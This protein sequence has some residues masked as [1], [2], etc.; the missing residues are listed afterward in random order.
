MGVSVNDDGEDEVLSTLANTLEVLRDGEKPLELGEILHPN[1]LYGWPELELLL[2]EH[3]I[4]LDLWKVLVQR[5]QTHLVL[6][7]QGLVQ[8]PVP[9][10]PPALQI[11]EAGLF[12]LGD[13]LPYLLQHVLPLYL[14]PQ[15]VRVHQEEHLGSYLL[16][17][18][19]Q[20][21]VLPGQPVRVSLQLLYV[22]LDGLRVSPGHVGLLLHQLSKTHSSF[23]HHRPLAGDHPVTNCVMEV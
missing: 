19:G 16:V 10:G 17:E 14:V 8:L 4:H 6:V 18:G 7:L 3:Q 20:G 2:P 11:A 1:F 23:Q 13:D 12:Y 22:C 9:V 21:V 5:L 15:Q